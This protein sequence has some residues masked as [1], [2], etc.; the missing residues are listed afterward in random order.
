MQTLKTILALDYR[1]ED[2]AS[3]AT[4]SADAMEGEAAAVFQRLQDSAPLD[5]TALLALRKAHAPA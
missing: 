2:P 4:A 1:I 5:L 3:D